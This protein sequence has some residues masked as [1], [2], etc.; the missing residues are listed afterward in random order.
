MTEKY[1]VYISTHTRKSLLKISS[2]WIGRIERA[3]DA[4]ELNPYLGEKM[5]GD[6]SDLRK[7]K[8]W[9][10]RIIYRIEKKEKVIK[11]T[12]VGHR[13]GMSYK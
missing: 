5:N 9:P 2:P 11:I 8:V 6:M 12:E 10:Y 7:I 1:F 4:L 3:I 13:G